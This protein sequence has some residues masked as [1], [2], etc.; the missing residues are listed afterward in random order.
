[1][2]K[3]SLNGVSFIGMSD[4]QRVESRSAL[5]SSSLRLIELRLEKGSSIAGR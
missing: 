5:P 2:G 1:M 4:Y 3:S